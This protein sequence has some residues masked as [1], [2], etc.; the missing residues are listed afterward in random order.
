MEQTKQEKS[1][2]RKQRMALVECHDNRETRAINIDH[3]KRLISAINTQTNEIIEVLGG[4]NT[5]SFERILELLEV[6]ITH[7]SMRYKRK[8]E[9]EE[10]NG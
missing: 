5:S 2:T 10:I 4:I 6:T 1:F 7:R 3:N 8:E 9:A